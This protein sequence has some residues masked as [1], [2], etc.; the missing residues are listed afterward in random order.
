MVTCSL[1]QGGVHE[2]KDVPVKVEFESIGMEGDV[3]MNSDG[4]HE[5]PPK[6]RFEFRLTVGNEWRF[7]GYSGSTKQYL[8][9]TDSSGATLAPVEFSS[10][11]LFP[12][13]R[14][15]MVC[16]YMTGRAEEFPASGVSWLRLHGTL[17]IPL[18]R[19]KQSPAY[20]LPFQEEAKIYF[21]L[22]GGDGDETDGDIAAAPEPPTATLFLKE[23]LHEEK[24]GKKMIRAKITME[25]ESPFDLETFQLVDEKGDVQKAECQ[26][27]S[28][29]M[30]EKERSWDKTLVFEDT[31]KISKLRIRLVYKVPS[32]TAVVPVDL[33]VGMG[34][35]VRKKGT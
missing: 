17:K 2:Q 25:T 7:V 13:I 15:G 12:S 26:E 19:Q 23:Y 4:M 18:A 6:L 16:A 5:L 32:K 1:A 35:E 14:Q 21:P 27:G 30:G 33:K 22:P 34:G 28:S 9:L 29:S 8:K 11:Y 20:E 3:Y 31:G 10:H 24:D